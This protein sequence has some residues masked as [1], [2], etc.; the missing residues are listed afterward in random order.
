[1]PGHEG[2]G[3]GARGA[4][5]RRVLL[6]SSAVTHDLRGWLKAHP[7]AAGEIEATLEQ[8]SADASHLALRVHKLRG[9]LAGCW[10]CVA[11][12]DLRGLSSTPSMKGQRRSSCWPWELTTR[13]IDIE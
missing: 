1:V 7:T 4:V 9:P 6:R 12:Y 11:G 8:L 10:A 3:V 13:S 5:I 2:G